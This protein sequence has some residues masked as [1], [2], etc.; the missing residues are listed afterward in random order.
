[1]GIGTFAVIAAVACVERLVNKSSADGSVVS[2]TFLA[3]YAVVVAVV[4]GRGGLFGERCWRACGGRETAHC[5]M[6][7][8]AC[9]VDWI[10]L[11]RYGRIDS[12]CTRILQGREVVRD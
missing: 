11:E 3:V 7:G 9:V 8:V 10:C 1:V 6:F 12:I 5:E 2:G 4:C